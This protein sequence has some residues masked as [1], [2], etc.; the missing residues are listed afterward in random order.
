MIE[1]TLILAGLFIYSIHLII[2]SSLEQ[3]TNRL[4]FS[5]SQ[6]D[7]DAL[8]RR[9]DKMR[10]GKIT[11]LDYR[12][13][14]FPSQP[15]RLIHSN[16][17]QNFSKDASNYHPYDQNEKPNLSS[18]FYNRSKKAPTHDYDLPYQNTNHRSDLK[19]PYE[20]D[21]NLQQNSP[22]R[23]PSHIIDDYMQT[24]DQIDESEHKRLRSSARHPGREAG[25]NDALSYNN[26]K[27]TLNLP[28][29]LSARDL[30]TI[31]SEGNSGYPRNHDQN[32]HL[33]HDNPHRGR[34]AEQYRPAENIYQEEEPYRQDLNHV[35]SSGGFSTATYERRPVYNNTSAQ[36]HFGSTVTIDPRRPQSVDTARRG[37]GGTMKG[38]P[39]H[40]RKEDPVYET[41]WGYDRQHNATVT[42]SKPFSAYHFPYDIAKNTHHPQ[43]YNLRSKIVP[44]YQPIR[45]QQLDVKRFKNNPFKYTDHEHFFKNYYHQLRDGYYENYFNMPVAQ[46]SLHEHP[47]IENRQ[48]IA[49]LETPYTQRASRGFSPHDARLIPVTVLQ[50]D[51]TYTVDKGYWPDKFSGRRTPYEQ[52]SGIVNEHLD[53]KKHQILPRANSVR[54]TFSN[55]QKPSR[56][57][58]R[59]VNIQEDNDTNYDRRVDIS[60]SG[61]KIPSQ[62]SKHVYSVPDLRKKYAGL[63]EKSQSYNF[64]KENPKRNQEVEVPREDSV[65][66]YNF[67]NEEFK[68]IWNRKGEIRNEESPY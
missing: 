16:S 26:S 56:L 25:R 3:F 28:A 9:I 62:S 2:L 27:E 61:Q 35:V 33:T 43:A 58:E 41:Y 18:T 63:T 49:E 65:K 7:F 55:F 30:Y 23:P 8:V 54:E 36:K 66:D 57:N 64:A 5:F 52:L 46:R 20:N 6:E 13:G 12:T 42:A 38:S 10:A 59:H 44:Y 50:K 19:A 17:Y 11:L 67:E 34:S 1:G 15:G 29:H 47:D 48:E 31:D 14:L 68:Q 21:Y 60:Q 32:D 40:R 45:D 53:K 37:L 39:L 22:Y 24:E 51:P 4:Q